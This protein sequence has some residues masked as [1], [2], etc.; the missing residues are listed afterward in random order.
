MNN[1]DIDI[2]ILSN[3]NDYELYKLYNSNKYYHNLPL[4]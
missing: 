3:M 4:N 2:M 1:R